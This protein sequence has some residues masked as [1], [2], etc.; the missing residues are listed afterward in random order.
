MWVEGRKISI[1][2]FYLQNKWQ[3]C[4][5]AH[6]IFEFI[7]KINGIMC[8]CVCMCSVRWRLFLE[9]VWESLRKCSFTRTMN[10]SSENSVRML[11]CIFPFTTNFNVNFGTNFVFFSRFLREFIQALKM[12]L[13]R[14]EDLPQWKPWNYF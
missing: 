6:G 8:L 7:N 4:L 2:D 5:P 14:S 3:C 9:S 10:T 13:Q 12:H 1:Q 11:V